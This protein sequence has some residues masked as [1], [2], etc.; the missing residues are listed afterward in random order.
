M[1]QRAAKIWPEVRPADCCTGGR[2]RLICR[3]VFERLRRPGQRGEKRIKEQRNWSCLRDYS[4]TLRTLP[5]TR[6]ANNASW[7]I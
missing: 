2:S 4:D 7:Q 1:D 6:P 5:R 3:L